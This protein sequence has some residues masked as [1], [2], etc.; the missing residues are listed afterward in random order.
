MCPGLTSKG[1]IL[2]EVSLPEETVVTIMAEGKTH[3]LGVGLLKMSTGDIKTLNRGNGVDNI[4]CLA[5]GLWKYT[6]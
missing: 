5:D 1:A 4:H 2:P 6:E 3:A